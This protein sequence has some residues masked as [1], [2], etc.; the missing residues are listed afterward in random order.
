MMTMKM[1]RTL[2]IILAQERDSSVCTFAP[3]KQKSKCHDQ[4][5][6]DKTTEIHAK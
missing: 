4:N 5:K 6:V 3:Y 2:G 1:M